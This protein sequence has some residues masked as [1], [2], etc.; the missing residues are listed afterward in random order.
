M[1]PHKQVP[2]YRVVRPSIA[3]TADKSAYIADRL[4]PSLADS[5]ITEQRLLP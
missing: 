5:V 1:L 3:L 4:W 2:K